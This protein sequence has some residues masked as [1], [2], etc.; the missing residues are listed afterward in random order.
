LRAARIQGSKLEPGTMR[1]ELNDYEWRLIKPMLPTGRA[2]CSHQPRP[3]AV[4]DHLV[5][6]G[7]DPMPGWL[8]K[9]LAVIWL[10]TSSNLRLDDRQIAMLETLEYPADVDAA[11]RYPSVALGP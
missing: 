10:M 4:I 2:I 7:E 5:G 3:K 9:L 8:A 11:C 1:Y 6:A